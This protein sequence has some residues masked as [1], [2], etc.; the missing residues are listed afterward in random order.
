METKGGLCF[1]C[2]Y[3]YSEYHPEDFSYF[4]GGG[5]MEG[6]YSYT[7]DKGLAPY[8]KEEDR[9]KEIRPNWVSECPNFEVPIQ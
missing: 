1:K 6:G 3:L 9:Y 8:Q 5:Y 7:C 4:G 2:R